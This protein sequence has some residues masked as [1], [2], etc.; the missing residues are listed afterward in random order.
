MSSET[1]S[2]ALLHTQIT[3]MCRNDFPH[4]ETCIFIENPAAVLQHWQ[5]FA[6]A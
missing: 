1:G 3:F 6:A 5:L 4:P 2:V